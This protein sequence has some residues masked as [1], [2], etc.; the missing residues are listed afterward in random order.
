MIARVGCVILAAGENRRFAGSQ[1]KLLTPVNGKPLLQHA[2]DAATRSKAMSCTLVIGAHAQRLLAVVDPRRCA[3]VNNA[4]WKEGIASSV[5]AGLDN[6]LAD[7]A[8]IF[9][10]GD[11]PFVGATDLDRLI[12]LHRADR[13]AIVALKSGDVWGTPML[14]PSNVFGSVTK[15]R[16]DAG[17]KR[18]AQRPG[19]QVRFVSA[20]SPFAF[21]DVDTRADLRRLAQMEP[22]T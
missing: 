1:P 9:M 18:I 3:V 21:A 4:G 14:L 11:D 17:A 8:C 13:Q 12:A 19:A 22:R 10:V 6:H 20:L 5:R 2:V 15:L 16:G 7:G